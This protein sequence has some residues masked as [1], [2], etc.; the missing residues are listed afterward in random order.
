MK[1][2]T[3]HKNPDFD[4]I[5]S[6][7]AAKK[8][9]P[10]AKILF[11]PI[12]ERST[13]NFMI[14]SI[15]Y[16][17]LEN[18]HDVNDID[19]L[20]VVDT[21]SAGRL[22]DKF[23]ETAQ[24]AYIICYDHHAEGD[25][26]C[27]ECYCD[28]TG[29]NVT[30][31][32]E[33]ILEK[34]IEITEDEATLFMLGIYQDTGKLSY[35]STTP[36]DMMVAAR[37]LQLGADLD[38]VRNIL[39]ETL[40]EVEVLLLNDLIKHKRVYEIRG[41]R[42][43]LSFSS[44]EEYV[45]NV[46]G[47]VT[48]FMKIDK[49]DAAICIF[50]MASRLYVIARSQKEIDVAKLLKQI[51]GGGHRNAASASVKNKT[52]IE[53]VEQ[54]SY[55]IKAT[56]LED[57]KAKEI[58][59]YPPKYVYGDEP[60]KRV[61]DVFSRS[62]VNALV[63]VDR[64]TG[65]VIGI[66]TRQAVDRAAHHH[67]ENEPI[68]SF[69]ET[70]FQTVDADD[71]FEKAR[72]LVVED[73][74]KLIPVTQ[75]GKLVG[76]IT[77]TNLLKLLSIDIE[78][79]P[80]PELVRNIAEEIKRTLPPFVVDRL[81]EIGKASKQMGF[82]SY[83]IGGA[84][85]D[86]ILGIENPEID[87]DIAV[88]DIDTK[89]HCGVLLAREIGRRFSAKV[90]EHQRFGTATVIFKDGTK[91]DI[92]TAREES[93]DVPGALPDV[94]KSSLKLDLY[95]RDFTINTLAVKLHD[96]F[97]DLFDFFGGLKDIRERKIRVLHVLSFIDDPTRIF[98]AIRFAAKL[99]F[100][101]GK[102]TKGLIKSAIKAGVLKTL[103]RGRIFNEIRLILKTPCV[104]CSFELFKQYDVLRALDKRLNI[105]NRILEH[106]ERLDNAIK[107]Q[108]TLYPEI[109]VEA[110]FAYMI[111]LEYLYRKLLSFCQT[112]GADEHTLKTIKKQV[113]NI[114]KVRGLL[115]SKCNNNLEIYEALSPLP[116]E[117][118]LVLHVLDK[119]N[120][121][122]TLYLNKL[123]HIKPCIRGKDLLSMGFKPSKLFSEIIEDVFKQQILYRISDKAE[124]IEYVKEKYIKNQNKDQG[125]QNE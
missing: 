23:K 92:A 81:M 87:L 7:I 95:R 111:L 88:E 37:L 84:V 45:G 115:R 65:E 46:A 78:K 47:I 60:L 30:Q 43:G 19:T 9:Y 5:S 66:V 89:E 26:K 117:T 55:A 90:A 116:I 63:V 8:L 69:M 104:R 68:S 34:R 98:R 3:T 75:N 114:P 51:G 119:E 113:S 2:I 49:L 52:L 99:D 6:C 12:P 16:P 74:Q 67:M 40:T 91:I 103:S 112:I 24:K 96:E 70:E 14:Q 36:R 101:I 54:L 123:M 18:E 21:R 31:M 110:D 28:K 1:V 41:K 17:Y 83:L 80:T 20:I 72:E 58:M 48:R 105:D 109:P 73:K 118:V 64:K 85:R 44:L 42:V 27:N 32:V 93:Y 59:S 56:L 124:A 107:I 77:R 79:S 76:V 102:Q 15:I 97:G 13:K 57:I 100:E 122:I 11:P 108:K 39:E 82:K 121:K 29:A 120:E 38:T 33:R 94:E 71:S 53:V 4:A 50:R 86:V 25:L 106:L 125:V 62:G 10:E 61:W 22:D 35:S